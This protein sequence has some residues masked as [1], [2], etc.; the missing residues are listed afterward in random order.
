MLFS[1]PIYA[2]LKSNIVR[3]SGIDLVPAKDGYRY[4]FWAF[5]FI[6]GFSERLAGDF[7][8]RA[9]TIVGRP[10]ESGEKE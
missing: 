9:E 4:I 10:S 2:I 8:V 5:G 1:N 3:L 7:I 6:A